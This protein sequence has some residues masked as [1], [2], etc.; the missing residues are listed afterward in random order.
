MEK[1]T[2][3]KQQDMKTLAI[4]LSCVL[5]YVIVLFMACALAGANG[6]DE[7]EL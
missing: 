3:K 1:I 5:V 7:D 2:I 4:I 6:K